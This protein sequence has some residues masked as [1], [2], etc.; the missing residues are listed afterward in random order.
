M[1]EKIQSYKNLRVY[2]SAMNEGLPVCRSKGR[3]EI[4][5]MLSKTFAAGKGEAL[6]RFLVE[7]DVGRD[8]RFWHLSQVFS[9]LY[10]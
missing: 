10:P 5:K 2:Q 3:E 6:K 4:F 8:E 7:E 1:G 9:A